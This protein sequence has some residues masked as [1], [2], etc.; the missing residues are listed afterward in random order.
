MHI[1]YTYHHLAMMWLLLYHCN[2]VWIRNLFSMWNAWLMKKRNMVHDFSQIPNS[3]ASWASNTSIATMW[4]N[5]V[6]EIS[7]IGKILH[8]IQQSADQCR[9]INNWWPKDSGHIIAWGDFSACLS[10]VRHRLSFSLDYELWSCIK[11]RTDWSLP[12]VQYTQLGSWTASLP[13]HC[14]WLEPPLPTRGSTLEASTVVSSTFV[15]LFYTSM[16]GLK[17]LL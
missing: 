13:L 5:I 12:L 14:W 4:G 10:G 3:Y 8:C 7:C 17:P 15:I 9:V 16:C 11:G 2:Q 6:F 1:I